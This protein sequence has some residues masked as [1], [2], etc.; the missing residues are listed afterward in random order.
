MAIGIIPK[1][2]STLQLKS[3]PYEVFLA[4]ANKAADDLEWEVIHISNRGM[5]MRP[6]H[7][8][9][10]ANAEIAVHFSNDIV[11][12][13]S[14]STDR[15]MLDLGANK[16]NVGSFIDK[17]KEL[18]ENL[19]EDELVTEHENILP[20]IVYDY[21]ETLIDTRL[22]FRKKITNL[23]SMLKPA[24][25]YIVTPAIV[26]L[27]II[28]FL[29]MLS[30]GASFFLPQPKTILAWG[31]NFR[32]VTMMGEW[33]RLLTS[34]FLHYGFFHLAV[35][36]V[37]LVFIGR[38]IEPYL[39][40]WR[41]L[42]AYLS[43]GLVASTASIWWSDNTISAGASGAIFGMYGLFLALL[44]TNLI[45]KETRKP[46]LISIAL[47][48]VYNLIPAEGVDNMAHIGGLLSGII[49]GYV[50]V[51]E[52]KNPD[53]YLKMLTNSILIIAI[54]VICWQVC[55]GLKTDAHL[56][57]SKMQEFR[58]SEQL[59]LEVYEKFQYANKAD[60][61]YELKDRS[62]YYWN[63]NLKI[64]KEIHVMDIPEKAREI[65]DQLEEY[66]ELHIECNDLMY[67]AISTGTDIYND[68]IDKCNEKILVIGNSLND[69]LNQ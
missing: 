28:I 2:K 57:E 14:T 51:P 48:I 11:T 9:F 42:S 64:V 37:S 33:W 46:L 63:E 34:V 59:A 40:R 60:I 49:I 67:K 21:D 55:S 26:W 41:F 61:L 13:C 39:G 65:N 47:F 54:P 62:N 69:I 27:N 32:P 4:F 25:G 16:K 30:R 53:Y 24:E 23:F 56:Y 45:D 20:Q 44:T 52:L 22:T 66:C 36:M 10:A 50:I 17:I 12:V 1:F 5:K 31:G 38:I 35:N 43:T 3:L 15:N 19:P 8:M 68:R 58:E 6:P 18:H 7:G 29:L